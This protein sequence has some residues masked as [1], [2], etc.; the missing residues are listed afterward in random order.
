MELTY[1][2]CGGPMDFKAEIET[3]SLERALRMISQEALPEATAHTLNFIALKVERKARSNMES[4]FTIRTPYTRNSLR[5]QRRA[6]GNNINRMYATVG[7]S[8]HYLAR[9]DQGGRIRAK[10]F[11]IPIPTLNAR[12]GSHQ[13]IILRKFAMNQMGNFGQSYGGTTRF[14]TGVPKGGK[15]K[16]GIYYRHNNNRSLMMI[17]NLES[18]EVNIKKSGWFTNAVEDEATPEKIREE[19]NRNARRVIA[20]AQRRA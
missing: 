3:K 11:R 9:Q 8:S 19:F 14:F 20:R 17:R 12:G 7:S 15:R 16:L 13:S 5:V 18:S 6:R 1:L 2:C 4:K 10:K